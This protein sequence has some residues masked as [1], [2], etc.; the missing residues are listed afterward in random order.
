MP[1]DT[2][3]GD[4]SSTDQFSRRIFLQTA[5]TVAGAAVMPAALCAQPLLGSEAPGRVTV[6]SMALKVNRAVHEVALEPRV[7][8]LEALRDHLSLVGT[9]KG[10][11]RGQ[12]GACT[13]LINGRRVNS[14]LTLAVM[15]ANDDI[16]TVEGLASAPGGSSAP[17]D[18]HPM[19]QAFLQ[20]DA[21]QC[22]YC[23]PG[24]ICS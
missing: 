16:V 8:L 4:W 13:V 10:C 12:C 19:Q 14:C 1:K 21:L 15:H 24:Q 23:T 18:L 7:T 6:T 17:G 20:H 2:V 9:K 5:A 3:P 22:G 11:D